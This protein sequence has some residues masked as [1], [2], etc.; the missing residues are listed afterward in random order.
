MW[1]RSRGDDG[2]IIAVHDFRMAQ[3][4][5]VKSCIIFFSFICPDIE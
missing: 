3:F 2:G 5:L 1:T 4:F